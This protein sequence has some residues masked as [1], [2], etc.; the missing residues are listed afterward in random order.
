VKLPLK[1]FEE[2]KEMKNKNEKLQ[3]K[4]LISTSL[5]KEVAIKFMF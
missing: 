3:L 4:G 5:K 2:Y 1:V